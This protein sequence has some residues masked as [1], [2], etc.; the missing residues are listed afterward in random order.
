MPSAAA[1]ILGRQVGE[2]D[3]VVDQRARHQRF[4]PAAHVDVGLETVVRASPVPKRSGCSAPQRDDIVDVGAEHQHLAAPAP[5]DFHLDGQERR[6]LDRDIDL[7]GR[8]DEV[9]PAVSIAPQDTGEQLHERHAADRAAAIEPAA[10]ARDREPDV[11]AVGRIPTFDGRRPLA[12][13]A[14]LSKSASLSITRALSPGTS[15]PCCRS[16]P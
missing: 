12:R 14:C 5:R 7:L 16:E 2:F 6:I 4:E 8:R 9:V 11:A 13:S 1:V 10:I 15:I 3:E